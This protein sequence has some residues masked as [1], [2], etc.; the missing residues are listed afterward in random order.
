MAKISQQKLA[1]I[2]LTKNKLGLTDEEYRR[3]M[4]ASVGVRSAKDLTEEMFRKVLRDFVRS[5]FYQANDS[6]MTL[7][8]KWFIENLAKKMGWDS[9]H[10]NHFITK[11]FHEQDLGS[12][13]KKEASYLINA[14]KHMVMHY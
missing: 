14:L 10:L 11:H 2:H 4:F 7:K 6:G 5:P 12:L 1:V 8:Q 3:R 13:N 9:Q